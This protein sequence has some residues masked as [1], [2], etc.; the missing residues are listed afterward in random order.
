M[1]WFLIFLIAIL[2]IVFLIFLIQIPT[3]I[4]RSRGLSGSDI[5]TIT[6]LSW[7]GLIFGVTWFVALILSLIW[8][9]EMGHEC[10]ICDQTHNKSKS[11]A[12][13]QLEKL[14]KLKQRGVITQKEFDAEKKKIL[15]K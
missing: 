11:S 2:C 15:S 10:E 7:C 3:F 12:V 8:R 5:T 6:I 1:V 4:A 14:H 13:D 9:S